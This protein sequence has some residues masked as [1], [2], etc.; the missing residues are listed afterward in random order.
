MLS[1]ITWSADPAIFTIPAFWIFDAREVRWYGLAFAL[2]FII[3]LKIVGIMWKRENLPAPWLE[4]LFYYTLAGTAIGAR[5]G[6]CLF[7]API[8]Y[9][10]NPIDIFKIW[11]GG[12]ASHGGVLGIIISTWIYS[13]KV[14][15]KSMLW[16][17]DKLVVPTGLVSCFIRL[18]NLM[19]HEIYGVPT[20]KPWAFRFILNLHSW[21]AG[22]EP[23]YTLP[24]HPTQ[25]YEALCYLIIFGV[26][27][28]LY[29]KK[30]AYL[31]EGLIFGI[32]MTW[33]FGTRFIIEYVKEVQE[34]FEQGLTLNMG[35][36]L[37][38]PFVVAGIYFIVRALKNKPQDAKNS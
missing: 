22:A 36:M 11:E 30:K 32:F 7:Y 23:L 19:N 15:R 2:G 20:D 13:K 27:L 29:F 31:R 28:W 34:P 14:S 16:A 21:K 37:S 17:F 38:I 4:K 10:A 9:L 33:V 12:L 3:G 6:H 1:F 35:Q 24:V 18:G 25:L 26:C 8:S 5:L